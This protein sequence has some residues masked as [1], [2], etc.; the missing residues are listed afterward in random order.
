MLERRVLRHQGGR[1]GTPYSNITEGCVLVVPQNSRIFIF[2]DRILT[3]LQAMYLV[4]NKV[5]SN[6]AKNTVFLHI[7]YNYLHT[8]N[9]SSQNF[10]LLKIVSPER[11]KKVSNTCQTVL[12]E[13]SATRNV[14]VF[15]LFHFYALQNVSKV[16]SAS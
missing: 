11:L 15:A 6:E 13:S 16:H 7:S 8:C 4:S 2:S 1:A 9:P 12:R 5:T 14:R 10:E 3:I